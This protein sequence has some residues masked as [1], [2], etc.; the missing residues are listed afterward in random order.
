MKKIIRKIIRLL[1]KKITIG[2]LLI[3][4]ILSIG[5][6]M[7]MDFALDQYIRELDNAILYR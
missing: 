3:W 6:A 2:D 1:N 5:I 4:I 7:L